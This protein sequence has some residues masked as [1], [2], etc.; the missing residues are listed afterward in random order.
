MRAPPPTTEAA[1]G[2]LSG[3]PRTPSGS[4]EKTKDFAHNSFGLW[5]SGGLYR[6]R[7]FEDPFRLRQPVVVATDDRSHHNTSITNL[8]EYLA[9]EIGV[10]LFRERMPATRTGEALAR[11]LGAL[12]PKGR[13]GMWPPFFWIQHYP[14]GSFEDPL[15]DHEMLALVSFSSYVAR[16]RPGVGDV[17]GAARSAVVVRQDRLTGRERVVN[18]VEQRPRLALGEPSWTHIDDRGVVEEFIG[19]PLDGQD[20]NEGDDRDWI[21]GCRR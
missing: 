20:I 7:V 14:E 11:G 2:P 5:V 17:D 8:A 6:M 18:R 1:L 13:C 12:M 21:R 9:A 10:M 16:G 4:L 3:F 15:S 19:V